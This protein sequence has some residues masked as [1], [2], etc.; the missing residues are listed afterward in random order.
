MEEIIMTKEQKN[1]II[2][3]WKTLGFLK[4]LKDGSINEW[5]C[6]KSFDDIANF[7]VADESENS[8]KIETVVFPFMRRVLCTGKKRVHRILK[9]EEVSN[10]FANTKV[11]DC[12][13]Y[14]KEPKT[15]ANAKLRQIMLNLM[16]NEWF[17]EKT[18]ADF[19]WL[20]GIVKDD[21]CTFVNEILKDVFDFEAEMLVLASNVFVETVVE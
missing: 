10:F 17:A 8:R 11:K 6:A 1:E 9:A 12:V 15:K 7:L 2:A 14:A 3:K 21:K 18:L 20:V 5:R 4:G 16:N 13:K 19:F